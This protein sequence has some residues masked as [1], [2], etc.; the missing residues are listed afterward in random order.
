MAVTPIARLANEMWPCE[1]E[2]IVNNQEYQNV[3]FERVSN[4]T[5]IANRGNERQNCVSMSA[6][7]PIRILTLLLGFASAYLVTFCSAIL[8]MELS[9]LE[10]AASAIL[11]GFLIVLSA[12]DVREL[13]LPNR[14]TIPLIGLGLGVTWLT[15][16]PGWVIL[17]HSLAAAA[18]WFLAMALDVAYR[19][20]RGQHGLGGG[21]AKLLAA[22][23]AWVGPLA[24]PPLLL[25]SCLSALLYA[26]LWHFQGHRLDRSSRL[27]FGPHIAFAVWI[28]WLMHPLQ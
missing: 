25:W 2:Q 28:V 12:I 27:P 9:N 23:A 24:M 6:K 18:A 15:A 13:R 20:L 21:D 10:I 19:K 16:S 14:L 8:L 17:H 26:L 4:T 1:V 11:A 22:G 7:L 5:T 3:S